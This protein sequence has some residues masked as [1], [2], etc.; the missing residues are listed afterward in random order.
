MNPKLFYNW[1]KNEFIPNLKRFRE[2]E[3]KIRKVILFLDN[4]PYHP[5]TKQLNKVNEDFE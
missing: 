2:K 4:A 5:N 3:N 1:Y